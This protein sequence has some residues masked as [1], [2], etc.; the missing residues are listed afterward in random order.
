MMFKNENDRVITKFETVISPFIDKR[1]LHRLNLSL[2]PISV[3]WI[4]HG[5][6]KSFHYR[7]VGRFDQKWLKYFQSDTG[8][9]N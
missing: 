4:R 7:A 3:K 5:D 8:M 1:L 2:F 6:I 9:I